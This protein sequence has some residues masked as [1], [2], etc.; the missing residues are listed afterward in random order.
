M[1]FAA[2]LDPV[3]DGW[4]L[5]VDSLLDVEVGHG[6]WRESTPLGRPVVAAGAWRGDTFVA[7]LCVITTT[8][9]VRLSVDADTE[10]ATA[11]WNVVPLTSPRLEVQLRSPLMT[12]PDVA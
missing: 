12:R 10:T 11:T 8:H 4:V 6:R 1:P 5:R 2:V 7:D 9:R 3:A